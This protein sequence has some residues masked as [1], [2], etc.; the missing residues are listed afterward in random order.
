MVSV[1]LVRRCYEATVESGSAIP[2]VDSKDSV[3][4]I[5]KGGNEALERENIK[6]VQTPQSF[7]S[8]LILPAYSIDFKDKFTDE[9]SVME[10]FGLTVHLIPGE[11]NNIKITQPVDLIIA[12]Y[13]LSAN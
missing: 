11:E 9:A 3:R 5:I 12:E 10:A 7:H 8:K 13:L 4:R 6:M 1:D 2:V